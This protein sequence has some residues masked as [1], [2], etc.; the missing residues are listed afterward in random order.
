MTFSKTALSGWDEAARDVSQNP[1]CDPQLGRCGGLAA[2][3]L[4]QPAAVLT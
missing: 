2:H 4:L 1:E 3:G